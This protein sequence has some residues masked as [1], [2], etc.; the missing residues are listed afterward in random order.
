MWLSQSV[1]AIQ[2]RHLSHYLVNAQWP[3]GVSILRPH[4]HDDD[5]DDDD[6]KPATVGKSPVGKPSLGS[7]VA[8]SP[9]ARVGKDDDAP[10]QLARH[11]STPVTSS[12]KAAAAKTMAKSHRC[13]FVS[14][15]LCVLCWCTCSSSSICLSIHPFGICVSV[16]TFVCMFVCLFVCLFVIPDPAAPLLASSDPN[17][18]HPRR[19]HPPV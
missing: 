4:L 7:P 16:R 19:S 6:R 8:R 2:S 14:L 1:C 13:A 5:D 15:G 3:L 11:F 12:A 9:V 18:S 17:R 10:P